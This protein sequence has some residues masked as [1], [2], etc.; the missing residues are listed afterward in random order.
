MVV[1]HVL[2]SFVIMSLKKKVETKTNNVSKGRHMVC[3]KIYVVF[4]IRSYQK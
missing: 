1:L 2:G 3:V 4:F